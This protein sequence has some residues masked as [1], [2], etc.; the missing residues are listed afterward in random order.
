MG[1]KA[2]EVGRVHLESRTL[3]QAVVLHKKRSVIPDDVFPMRNASI[4]PFLE[5]FVTT[6]TS[7]ST[8]ADFIKEKQ[9][10]ILSPTLVSC[11]RESIRRVVMCV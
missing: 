3:I 9:G 5:T 7:L 1:E 8:Q 11:L 6:D 2:D 4:Q 10:L